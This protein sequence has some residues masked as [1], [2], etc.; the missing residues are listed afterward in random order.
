MEIKC[1]E[2]GSILKLYELDY[3]DEFGNDL[4]ATSNFEI[5]T[6]DDAVYIICKNCDNTL[7]LKV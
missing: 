4:M 3:T 6:Y 1:T 2:C 7:Y 5:I